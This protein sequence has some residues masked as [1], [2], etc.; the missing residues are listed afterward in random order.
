MLLINGGYMF[1]AIYA[2]VKPF[3]PEVTK[4][5]FVFASKRALEQLLEKIDIDQI[6]T[7]YGGNGPNLDQSN[8]F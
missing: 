1:K 7:D 6:P 3:I 2:T 8:H 4:Q 5:K